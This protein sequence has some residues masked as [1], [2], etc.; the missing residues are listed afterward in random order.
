MNVE[1]TVANVALTAATEASYNLP[2]FTVQFTIKVRSTTATLQLAVVSGESG[3]TYITVPPGSG[4]WTE[5][6]KGRAAAL[7]L[8]FQSNETTTAEIISWHN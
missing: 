5:T 7:T 3:T 8:Y 1:P 2:N 4:G 6:I